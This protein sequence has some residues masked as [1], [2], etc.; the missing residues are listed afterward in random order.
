MKVELINVPSELNEITL[1]QYQKFLKIQE[2]VGKTIT[3]YNVK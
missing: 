1:K 3:L 2:T